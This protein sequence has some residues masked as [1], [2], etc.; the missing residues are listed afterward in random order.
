[1]CL[2]YNAARGVDGGGVVLVSHRLL[3]TQTAEYLY[4]FVKH[5][6]SY[7]FVLVL[8]DL[9]PYVVAERNSKRNI[10][11]REGVQ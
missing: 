8:G 9:H 2:L 1:M 3:V 4:V 6:S 11:D 10:T 5:V 7:M